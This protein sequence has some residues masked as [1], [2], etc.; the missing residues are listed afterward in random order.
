MM[1][2]LG[3]QHFWECFP[4]SIVRLMVRKVGMKLTAV[5]ISTAFYIDRVIYVVVV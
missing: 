3:T 1:L 5:H 4:D 2:I